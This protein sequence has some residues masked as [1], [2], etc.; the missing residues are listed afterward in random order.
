MTTRLVNGPRGGSY[1]ETR[2]ETGGVVREWVEPGP[3]RY[4]TQD[5]HASSAP[6]LAELQPAWPEDPT[7]ESAPPRAR[8]YF[9]AS[10]HREIESFLYSQDPDRE[11]GV[12][13]R[14]DPQCGRV[15]GIADDHGWAQG[16]D[17]RFV[18]MW[19]MDAVADVAGHLH[20]HNRSSRPSG[21]D[22][23]LW[24]DARERLNLARF[25]GVLAL[26]DPGDAISKPQLNA[27][28]LSAQGCQ[29]ANLTVGWDGR[30]R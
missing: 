27:Y 30:E 28:V 16:S 26:V 6:L 19:S 2:L 20:S 18:D 14:G 25:V 29:R 7:V 8:V 11:A 17:T 12:W 21:N 24:A 4:A 23:R 3:D 13:L 1:L 15:W 5:R 22:L 10:A 9:S